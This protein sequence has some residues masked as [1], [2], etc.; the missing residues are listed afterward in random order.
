MSS[1]CNIFSFK[2]RIKNS[3]NTTFLS[4]SLF[5]ILS[6][7]Y[8]LKQ[9]CAALPRLVSLNKVTCQK[10]LSQTLIVINIRKAIDRGISEIVS[11]ER[12]GVFFSVYDYIV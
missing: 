8:V 3:T 1:F 10:V 11:I 6:E 7:Y 2:N 5:H 4:L 12:V 9:A